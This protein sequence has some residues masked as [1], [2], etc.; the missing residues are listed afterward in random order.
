M[1]L[2]DTII[3]SKNVLLSLAAIITILLSSISYFAK[4]SDV[5]ALK[6]DYSQFK[7]YN[8]LMY[9]DKRIGDLEFRYNCLDEGCMNKMP[10]SV[11][12]EYKEKKNRKQYIEKTVLPNENMK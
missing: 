2:K 12:E 3:E 7:T 9:L 1:S 6:Q 10:Q 11:W 8:E 5:E 4:A